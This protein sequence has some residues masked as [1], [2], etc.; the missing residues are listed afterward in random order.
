[1][2]PLAPCSLQMGSA[3]EGPVLASVLNYLAQLM[4]R[5]KPHE[6][7]PRV[8]QELLPGLMVAMGDSRPD[9]RKGAVSCLVAMMLVLGAEW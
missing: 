8:E 9:V 4:E 3:T 7:R 1:M 2:P 6:L 5:L